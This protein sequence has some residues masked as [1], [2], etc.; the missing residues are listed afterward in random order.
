MKV[1][2]VHMTHYEGRDKV[3][4]YIE[5]VKILVGEDQVKKNVFNN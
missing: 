2:L 4:L 5:H 1:Y 3:T